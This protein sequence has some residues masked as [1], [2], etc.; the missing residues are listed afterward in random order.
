MSRLTFS[1]PEFGFVV[2][3]R[4][5]LALGAGLLI[6]RRLTDRRRVALGKALIAI[7]VVTTV[8]AVMFVRRGRRKSRRLLAGD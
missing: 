8:P 6:S 1:P 2:A 3:T 4:I 7:G 5:A